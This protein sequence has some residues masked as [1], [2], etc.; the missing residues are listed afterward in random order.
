MLERFLMY[1]LQEACE[2]GV[3]TDEGTTVQRS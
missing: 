3:F 1:P 2:G